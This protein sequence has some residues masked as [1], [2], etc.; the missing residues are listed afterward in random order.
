MMAT[1]ANSCFKIKNIKHFLK[2]GFL[3]LSFI[4]NVCIRICSEGLWEGLKRFKELILRK[5]YLKFMNI[6]SRFAFLR[7]LGVFCRICI[8]YKS[9]LQMLSLSNYFNK[10][11]YI[12]RQNYSCSDPK[13]IT[14]FKS[15]SSLK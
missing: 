4:K 1:I 11:K 15:N 9:L 5:K 3:R 13:I 10:N 12:F 6:F 7:L 8:F 2:N 14:Y